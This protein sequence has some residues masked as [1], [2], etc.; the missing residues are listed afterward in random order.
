MGGSWSG[1]SL[2]ALAAGALGIGA[3]SAL[4]I[5]AGLGALAGGALGLGGYRSLYDRLVEHGRGAITT[6]LGAVALETESTGPALT[7]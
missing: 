1:W 3:G 5:P 7:G 2:A 6:F 4:L